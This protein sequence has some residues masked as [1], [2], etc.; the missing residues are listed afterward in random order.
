MHTLCANMVWNKR[1]SMGQL[2]QHALV[3]ILQAKQTV[4]LRMPNG[5][6]AKLCSRQAAPSR[7]MERRGPFI[8]GRRH[9]QQFLRVY[10]PSMLAVGLFRPKASVLLMVLATVK[11]SRYTVAPEAM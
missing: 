10:V 3:T 6:V 2:G 7:T 5:F 9:A 11:E 4:M 8:S 1:R